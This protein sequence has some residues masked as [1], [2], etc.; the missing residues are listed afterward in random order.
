[1]MFPDRILA[2]I[3]HSHETVFFFCMGFFITVSLC[4]LALMIDSTL[5]HRVFNF[6]SS[7]SYVGNYR[8]FRGELAESARHIGFLNDAIHELH[9]RDFL[10][11]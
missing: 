5:R 6:G 3:N 4:A 9:D 2:V 1:M 10:S 8:Q 7:A 11:E